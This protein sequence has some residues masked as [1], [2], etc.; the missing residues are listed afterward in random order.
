MAPRLLP[1]LAVLLAV[2]LPSGLGEGPGAASTAD[3]SIAGFAFSPASVAVDQGDSVRWTN[4]DA[5]AHT[6]TADGGAWDTGTIPAGQSR[7]ASF[8]GVAAG[9]Y[10][11]HCAIHPFMTARVLLSDPAALPDLTVVDIRIA[12]TAMG[13]RKTIDVTVRND[14]A[15][16]ALAH[17]LLVAYLANGHEHTIADADAPMIGPFDSTI[18]EVTWNAVGQVGDFTVL[19]RA[20]SRGEVAESDEANNEGS[21]VTSVLLPGMPGI[22]VLDLLGGT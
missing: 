7:T 8:A 20:D 1:A 10:G 14:G 11:Y 5:G 15:H 3:V 2:A 9:T 6:S 16:T 13:L 21:T 17:H 12:D 19:A 22:D 18:V 4:N